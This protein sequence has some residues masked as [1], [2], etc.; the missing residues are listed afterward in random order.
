MKVRRPDAMRQLQEDLDIL[1]TLADR[2]ARAWEPA[3][4]YDVRG[5]VEEV[6]R[7]LRAELDY[8]REAHNAERFAEQFSADPQVV[9][10]RV[11]WERTTS[12]V[13]TL[14]RV[15]GIKIND[16]DALDAAG[17]DREVLAL[18]GSEIVLNMLFEHRFF[19]PTPTPETLRAAE[20]EH[21]SHRLRNGRGTQRGRT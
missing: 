11:F 13:L 10:P 20:R 1:N 5:L 7:T 21:C 16:L 12:R 6:S 2:A 18:T 9:I 8:L 19:Q 4:A 14:E 15:T 3:R 17:I